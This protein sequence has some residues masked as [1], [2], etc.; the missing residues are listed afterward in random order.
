MDEDALAKTISNLAAKDAA[1]ATQDQTAETLRARTVVLQQ[2]SEKI[3]E[4]KG[5]DKKP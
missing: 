1:L 5:A 3:E 2:I 4:T